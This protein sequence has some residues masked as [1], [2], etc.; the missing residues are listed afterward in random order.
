MFLKNIEILLF[1]ALSV[2]CKP[3]SNQSET[4]DFITTEESNK[5]HLTYL[6][7]KEGKDYVCTGKCWNESDP[8]NPVFVNPQDIKSNDERRKACSHE[9]FWVKATSVEPTIVDF[10]KKN[11]DKNY[12][13]NIK[14]VN[15]IRKADQQ[16]ASNEEKLPEGVSNLN[17]SSLPDGITELENF[18]ASDCHIG[19]LTSVVMERA[20]QDPNEAKAKNAVNDTGPLRPYEIG[21]KV[22]VFYDR[23]VRKRSKRLTKGDT[24]VYVEIM[25]KTKDNK[26]FLFVHKNLDYSSLNLEMWGDFSVIGGRQVEK[27]GLFQKNSYVKFW[28]IIF[29]KQPQDAPQGVVAATLENG[30]LVV[31][32]NLHHTDTLFAYPIMLSP[33]KAAIVPFQPHQ[34][35][36]T[37]FV[38]LDAKT[39]M[40]EMVITLRSMINAW[41]NV[42]VHR[43]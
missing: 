40:A 21:D 6:V 1:I 3:R 31:F 7:S 26:E 19:P 41:I 39:I 43:L 37:G 4:L 13:A 38:K 22:W 35:S 34:N 20:D 10:M 11:K 5:F 28:P 30:N 42:C 2:S 24:G 32:K 33:S 25:N 12:A 18:G 36:Y 16:K 29:E 27:G 17:T 9:L 14:V 23:E 8:K 15:G